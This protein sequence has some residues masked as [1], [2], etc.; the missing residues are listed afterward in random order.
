MMIPVSC[1][2]LHAYLKKKVKN[3]AIKTRCWFEILGLVGGRGKGEL[4]V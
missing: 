3:I 2:M 1:H 4:C